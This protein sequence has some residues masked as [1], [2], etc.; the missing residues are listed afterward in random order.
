MIPPYVT[1]LIE[2]DEKK[3][4]PNFIIDANESDY[5][6]EAIWEDFLVNSQYDFYG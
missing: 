2:D 4:E 5:D 1:D 6:E 3:K